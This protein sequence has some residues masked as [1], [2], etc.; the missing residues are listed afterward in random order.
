M[1]KDQQTDYA[2]RPWTG[3]WIFAGVWTATFSLVLLRLLRF[4]LGSELESY[5]PMVPFISAYLLYLKR[6]T[7]GLPAS[8]TSRRSVAAGIWAVTAGLLALQGVLESH[9]RVAGEASVL[10][11]PVMAF[12]TGIIGG[13]VYF[14][15][16]PSFRAMM[17][18]WLFLYFLVPIPEPLAHGLRVALQQGSAEAAYVMF[19]LTGTPVFRD[20]LAFCLPGL[21][22]QV[23]EECSGIH[24][25]LVLVITSLV[26]GHLFLNKTAGRLLLVVLV[27]PLCLIRNGFR[28]V[29]VSLL[30]IYVDPGI[31]DGPLHHRGGPVYFILSLG[32][33]VAILWGLRRFE[34]RRSG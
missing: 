3:F 11:L 2:G 1:D 8:V 19:K 22:I 30:T 13:V 10:V 34:R 6:E 21:T 5:V 12:V 15:G 20:G 33:L 7:R 17:F 28:I 25:S 29:S 24:S 23:A 14:L 4:S 32:V 18:P 31:I 26:A 16:L 9:G 27:L